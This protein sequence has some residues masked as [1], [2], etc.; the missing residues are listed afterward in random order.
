MFGGVLIA[1]RGAAACRIQATLRRMRIRAAA[2]Y[3]EADRHSLHVRQADEAIPIKAGTEGY[4]AIEE[5]M[6]A[7]RR[8]GVQA[9]HPGDR[10]D[11]SGLAEAC[12]SQEVVFIG[13]TAEQLRTF[14][15][16]QPAGR[17]A[18]LS[19]I[20]LAADA[21]VF[22]P[23]H[24]AVQIF[25]DGAGAVV[26]LGE[27]DCS[28]RRSGAIVIGETPAVGLTLDTRE[29]LMAA[30]VRIG[31]AV[32][33]RSA[34]TVEFIYDKDTEDFYFLGVTTSLTPE[35]ALCEETTG[36]DLVEWMVRLAAG[37]LPRLERMRIR[38]AGSAMQARV[39]AED[40]AKDFQPVFARLAQV[41][42]PAG[43]RIET[44][45]EPGLD[46]GPGCDPALA[47]II[48]RAGDRAAAL[49][50]LGH[51]LAHCRVAGIETNLSYLRQVAADP[52]FE[53]GGVATSFL[54]AFEYERHAI[55]VIEPGAETTVQDYPGR[56]GYEHA[57]VPPSGPMDAFALRM[58]NRLAGNTESAAALEV[59]GAGCVL[60]FAG[61][62][63]IAITGADIGAK[64]DGAPAPL[65]RSIP[66][67]TGSLLEMTAEP[68]AGCRAYVAVAGGIDV[69][70][71]L[72]SRSTYI[73]GRFGGHGGRGM[74]A[75]DV[76][77]IDEPGDAPRAP[78]SLTPGLI[79]AYENEWT[80][81]V[82]SGPHELPDGLEDAREDFFAAVWR[83]DADSDR[84]G[85]RLTGPQAA[86]PCPQDGDVTP[87]VAGAL[88]LQG[89][90]LVIHGPDGPTLSGLIRPATI[91]R[92]EL[93]KIG[94]LRSGDSV[95]F[96][97]ISNQQ[98]AEMEEEM[99]SCIDELAGSLPQLPEGQRYEEPVL[100]FGQRGNTATA[101][102]CRSEGDRHV[103]LEYAP[104][105]PGLEAR[106]RVQALEEH[107]RGAGLHGI[108]DLQSGV[109]SLHVHFDP[110]VLSRQFL[111]QALAVGE[112]SITSP[113]GFV[114]PSRVIHLPL[115]WEAD[116]SDDARA[117]VFAASYV[118][119]AVG[120]GS[121]GAP[122]AV[123]LDARHRLPAIQEDSA[124]IWIPEGG[125]TLAGAYLRVQGAEGRALAWLAG[126]TVQVWSS[127]GST[128]EFQ[129]GKPWL[130]RCFDQ[131]RFFPVTADEL[132]EIR[133]LFPRGR[134]P[135]RIERQTLKLKL[136]Q[137]RMNTD[138]RLHGDLSDALVQPIDFN[139]PRSV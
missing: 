4:G 116:E 94:Q 53:V 32:R 135:L 19:G 136:K 41:E 55:E 14:G 98:A 82:L 56:L 124:S 73:P 106:F 72:G 11:A 118:V 97:V 99:E 31:K 29:K 49:H 42:W 3:S 134:Y 64:L 34:G 28:A 121:P 102:E 68:A 15:E 58:A 50:R 112:D 95:R 132:V 13:P 59:A 77:S 128:G 45:V 86:F 61:D 100:L 27:I 10:S 60:S 87:C 22:R 6:D 103:L 5:V 117:A 12:E 76:L 26:A 131:I 127:F 125:V 96:R 46:A 71:Y 81:G 62:A 105:V 83:V 20:A 91:A 88:H 9:I 137:R 48:V 89:G 104:E 54:Q 85:V 66:V 114:T 122:V 1:S 7:A 115:C 47:Q 92:A 139:R 130:L 80:I 75:G 43:A 40:P 18:Q 129:Q 107:L 78:R 74:R 93:W 65:W 84:A 70:E 113:G 8:A 126:R 17:I 79:P 51:A 109:R 24:I 37:E 25:G 44:W 111:V 133:D 23:R 101:V 120:D 63:V 57:G 119:L 90:G 138:S 33:Y 30:A 39:A 36:V 108:L 21:D 123:P 67:S 35:H 69:P 110:R 16:N 52:A 38:P 2:I